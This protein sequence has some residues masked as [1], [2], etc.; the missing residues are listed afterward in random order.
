MS[1]DFPTV[2]RPLAIL[3]TCGLYTKLLKPRNLNLSSRW[4]GQK[5]V[6]K[7]TLAATIHT[8]MSSKAPICQRQKHGFL[9]RWGPDTVSITWVDRFWCIIEMSRRKNIKDL[10]T[11]P[12]WSTRQVLDHEAYIE[13]S[14]KLLQ[15]LNQPVWCFYEPWENSGSHSFT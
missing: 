4:C 7:V 8:N 10:Q 3:Q 9:K 11:A 14:S 2:L 12:R 15:G 13:Y 1:Y 5:E 6:P